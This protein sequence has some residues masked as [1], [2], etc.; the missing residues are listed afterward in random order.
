MT[1]IIKA[2]LTLQDKLNTVTLG[3]DWKNGP[4]DWHLAIS[5]ECA[6]GIDHLGWKWWAKQTQD[7]PAA[8]IELIDVLH[9]VL[10]AELRWADANDDLTAELA[11]SFQEYD[12]P[13]ILDETTF[14][15]ADATPVELF[16]L[17]SA[18][19]C[20]GYTNFGLVALLAQKLG[21]NILEMSVL[22]RQKATLNLFRQNNGYKDGT[23]VKHW[24][25][26]LEDNTFLDIL[27]QG[28]NWTHASAQ[29]LFYGRLN[30]KYLEVRQALT[31]H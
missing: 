30:V 20:V 2:M 1:P 12:Q 22:Y 16:Q 25:P 27:S 14:N 3:P 24:A 10:S 28:I 19:A 4:Q 21:M 8:R 26:G 18:M 9:F 15:V 5:Q 23:Y 6:E 17:I 7:L 29:D 11:Q 31:S 13:I